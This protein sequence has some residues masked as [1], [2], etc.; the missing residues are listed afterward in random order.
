[1]KRWRDGE[2][3]GVPPGAM[4]MSVTDQPHLLLGLGAASA[5]PGL[6]PIPLPRTPLPTTITGPRALRPAWASRGRHPLPIPVPFH[7]PLHCPSPPDYLW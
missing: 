2:R 5:A 7:L 4:H 6:T 3:G 1:M